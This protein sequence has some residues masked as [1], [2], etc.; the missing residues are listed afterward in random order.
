MPM[1]TISKLA[2]EAGVSVETIRFYERI[3]LLTRPATPTSGWRKYSETALASVRYVKTS[4][5]LGFTLSELD[6]LRLTAAAGKTAFCGSVRRAMLAKM[7]AVEEQ[8]TKL[9]A[10][11]RELQNLL[12][13]CGGRAQRSV[14]NIQRTTV[15][16]P[17]KCG[18]G[19]QDLGDL[20]VRALRRPL[21]LGSLTPIA[22]S[23]GDAWCASQPSPGGPRIPT[24]NSVVGEIKW[25]RC[26]QLEK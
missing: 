19:Q 12:T 21:L 23:A 1:M 20:N 26:Y 24:D 17:R 25:P 6:D 3:G 5:Q 15:D 9:Q 16:A 13:H 18:P 14:P 8:I 11:Q 2:K 10:V 4:Q 22:A 7:Q